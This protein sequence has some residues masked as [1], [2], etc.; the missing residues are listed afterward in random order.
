MS[1]SACSSSSPQAALV[2]YVPIEAARSETQLEPSSSQIGEEMDGRIVA[3]VN[4]QP[5][6]REAY[7]KQ[8][9]RFQQTLT[10][11]GVDLNGQSG[12]ADLAQIQ[13]QVLAAMIDQLIIEQQAARLNIIVTAQAVEAEAQQMAQTHSPAQFE[14]WLAANNLTFEEFKETLRAQLI[15]NQIFETVTSDVADATAR[16]RVFADWLTKQRA[17]AMI[18]RYVAF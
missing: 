17:A 15:A 11:Q 16:E 6:F 4:N 12:Q 3:R 8:V 7:E 9:A 10:G 14:A 13:Q 5:I 18:E 2:S 1:L